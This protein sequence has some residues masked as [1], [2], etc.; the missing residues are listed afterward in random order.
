MQ[1]AGYLYQY[2]RPPDF[3]IVSSSLTRS[4]DAQGERR[5]PHQVAGSSGCLQLPGFAATDIYPMR[6]PLI[7]ADY[8]AELARGRQYAEIGTR[9]GDIVACVRGLGAARAYAIEQSPRRW[10]AL[11]QRG[12]EVVGAQVNSTSFMDVLPDADVFFWW[13]I[14]E[15][16]L[17]LISWIHEAMKHRKRR[18]TVVVGYDWNDA[19]DAKAMVKQYAKV[20]RGSPYRNV[21]LTRLFFDESNGREDFFKGSGHVT[22][23]V[24][25][26]AREHSAATGAP[27][28]KTPL[29]VYSAPFAGRLGS[30][31]V[32]HLVEA[33]VGDFDAPMAAAAPAAPAAPSAEVPTIMPAPEVVSR[34]MASVPH[35]RKRSEDDTKQT[36]D[37]DV[38]IVGGGPNGL[39]MLACLKNASVPMSV[40]A[41]DKG[42]VGETISKMWYDGSVTHSPRETLSIGGIEPYEC[43]S[44]LDDVWQDH[45]L[46]GKKDGTCEMDGGHHRHCSREQL[47]A[48]MRRAQQ[49]LGL[50]VHTYHQVTGV[51]AQRSA[52]QQKRT[53]WLTVESRKHSGA[54]GEEVTSTTRAEHVVL[55]FGAASFRRDMDLPAEALPHVSSQLGTPSLYA[56]KHVVV[57]GTGPSGMESAIRVC[58]YG[59]AHVTLLTRGTT[60]KPD[61][62]KRESN[63][64]LRASYCRIQR[65]LA[66]GKM[67]VIYAATLVNAN[68]T[69]ADVRI[70]KAVKGKRTVTSEQVPAEQIV[71]AIGFRTD[72]DLIASMG[73]K[74]GGLNKTTL[75]TSLR[76]VYNLG[77]GGISPWTRTGRGLLQTA[78][79]DSMTDVQ[80]ICK[81]I[82]ASVAAKR[83]R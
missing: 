22:W 56:S 51:Q 69:H 50:R 5:A 25:R 27:A 73:F 19:G 40:V 34:P 38:A 47:V 67:T 37:H 78:I 39:R 45:Y 35:A 17:D 72:G 36:R 16:N 52:T 21:K 71:A 82:V 31:G 64:Y 77:L 58:N 4:A 2:I 12:L 10:P 14:A 7:V 3:S 65:F 70:S 15:I 75:E 6:S 18:A 74:D 26:K 80:S 81:A 20:A 29:P 49:L 57:V 32:F 8:L 33:Q 62:C 55:A 61:R 54:G 48:Y 13:I 68:G 42:D 30:W 11:R 9:D 46:D 23:Q 41:Y 28:P 44:C 76:G 1:S 63:V 53:Y 60:F 83:G 24:W 66:S 59:A 79:E 43:T